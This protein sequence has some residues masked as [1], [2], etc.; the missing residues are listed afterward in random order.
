MVGVA[1]L[2]TTEAEGSVC[3]DIKIGLCSVAPTPIRA[4]QAEQT[5]YGRKIES[6]TIELAARA[7]A[8][9]IRPRS[10][11]QYRRHMTRVL[12]RRAI[13]DAWR[14]IKKQSAV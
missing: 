8:E 11:P 7:A 2:M 14:Q 9:E 3:R 1:A 6:K 5:L 12:V 10:R 13:V 4:K